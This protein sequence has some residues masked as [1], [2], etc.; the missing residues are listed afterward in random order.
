MLKLMENFLIETQSKVIFA[1]FRL[2][3]EVCEL[4]GELCVIQIVFRPPTHSIFWIFG[5]PPERSPGRNF[6]R[7]PI[8]P[9]R[10][11]AT[12]VGESDFPPL[13]FSESSSFL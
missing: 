7:Y 2:L 11:G 13:T 3:L 6:V 5:Q 4:F 1:L 10:P 12:L 9:V 8:G